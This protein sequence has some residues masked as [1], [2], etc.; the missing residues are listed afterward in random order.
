MLIA[1]CTSALG[2]RCAESPCPALPSAEEDQSGNI[3][4]LDAQ[5]RIRQRAEPA[6]NGTGAAAG[7]DRRS[8]RAG[9][10][11]FHAKG[12]GLSRFGA[13][14]G[15]QQQQPAP[16]SLAALGQSE[17][18]RSTSASPGLAGGGVDC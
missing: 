9:R 4:L 10:T 12:T 8:W 13:A 7:G 17:R 5:R 14:L 18:E 2:L 3:S 15:Q 1:A 6:A 16:L 11:P